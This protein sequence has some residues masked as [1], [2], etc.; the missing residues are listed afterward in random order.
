MLYGCRRTVAEINVR[1]D[2]EVRVGDTVSFASLTDPLLNYTGRVLNYISPNEN[3]FRGG[4][5]VGCYYVVPQDRIFEQS[6]SETYQQAYERLIQEGIV[7]EEEL[8]SYFGVTIERLRQLQ[9]WTD[10]SLIF[11]G[12]EFA[13]NDL[14]S[15]YDFEDP[16]VKHLATV[17]RYIPPHYDPETYPH[18]GYIVAYKD[19]RSTR[20]ALFYQ[21]SK[22]KKAS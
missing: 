5:Y 4:Y 2:G 18:G 15:F 8:A 6:N 21:K 14:V 19:D 22:L 13:V 17:L 12:S 9:L 1:E 20:Q 11:D 3:G 7:G 16:S 10:E